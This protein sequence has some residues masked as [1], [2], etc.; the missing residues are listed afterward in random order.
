M[1]HPKVVAWEKKLKDILDKI[2]IYL[3]DTYGRKYTL[4]PSRSQRGMT[5]NKS[6][7][8]LFSIGA[9][10]TAGYGSDYGRGYV[11]DVD[12]VTLDSVPDSVEQQIEEDVIKMLQRE[13]PEAFPGKNLRIHKDGN[14]I[15]IHG[16]LSLGSL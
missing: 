3:E 6:H 7:D 2:D 9:S 10:F 13:L 4:H 5:S 16:D 8:G 15:K 1:R 12:M 11:V 14:R